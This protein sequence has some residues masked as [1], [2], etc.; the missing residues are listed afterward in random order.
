MNL[1]RNAFDY[2]VYPTDAGWRW[3]TFRPDAAVAESG[4]AESKSVAAACVIRALTHAY[5]RADAA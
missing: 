3:V 4:V 1:A 2:R 5:I